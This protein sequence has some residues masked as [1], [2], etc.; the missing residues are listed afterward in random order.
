MRASED[1]MAGKHHWCN[2]LELGQIWGDGEGQGGLVCSRPWGCKESYPSGWLNTLQ[3]KIWT[4]SILQN[5]ERGLKEPQAHGKG[6]W[7]PLLQIGNQPLF[8]LFQGIRRTDLSGPFW[9]DPQAPP[10]FPTHL[11]P[12][13]VCGTAHLKTKP[14]L[15]TACMQLRILLRSFSCYRKYPQFLIVSKI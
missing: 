2:G 3:R 15:S 6:W 7:I 1:E 5:L 12:Q 14:H 11:Q 10:L 4:T 8:P 9:I 13:C